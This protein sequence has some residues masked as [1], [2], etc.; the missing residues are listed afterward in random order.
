MAKLNLI[1]TV[2]IIRHCKMMELSN[3]TDVEKLLKEVKDLK[4]QVEELT[5]RVDELEDIVSDVPDDIVYP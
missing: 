3:M 1:K 2:L 5:E 4:K